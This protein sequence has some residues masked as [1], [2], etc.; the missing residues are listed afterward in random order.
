MSHNES[1]NSNTR[2]LFSI[3]H[4]FKKFAEEW[5]SSHTTSSPE[6][7]QSNGAERK[8]LAEKKDPFEGHNKPFEDI[9]VPPAKLECS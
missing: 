8:A 6:Y 7:P 5:G 3:D 2:H 4:E 9:G 1:Q